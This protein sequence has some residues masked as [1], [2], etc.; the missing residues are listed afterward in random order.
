MFD[1]LQTLFS[2]SPIGAGPSLSLEEDA[3]LRL[4]LHADEPVER[5]VRGRAQRVGSTLWAVTPRRL[6]C[7]TLSGKRPSRAHPHDSIERIEALMGKWGAT[8][9]VH[10]AATRE[11]I[12]AADP[13]MSDAFVEALAGYC[14]SVPAPGKL[15]APAPAPSAAVIEHYA[16]DTVP[17]GA[18]SASNSERLLDSLRQAAEL[19]DKGHLSEEEYAAAKRRLLGM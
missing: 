1:A 4:S 13:G 8:L 15:V 11:V 14:P 16:S 9:R 12:F 17:S 5:F 2:G 10:V 3:R 18:V 19:R 6:H 7:V